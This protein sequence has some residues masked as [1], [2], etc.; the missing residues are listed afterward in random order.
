[1]SFLYLVERVILQKR[2]EKRSDIPVADFWRANNEFLLSTK[3]ISHLVVINPP[4]PTA[5]PSN[6]DSVSGFVGHKCSH[7]R[8]K[9]L[10][11]LLNKLSLLK[12]LKRT[13]CPVEYVFV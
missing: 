7:D 9:I 4:H 1:M 5:L 2:L 3:F 10:I 13:F 8:L 11:F 12:F 6:L